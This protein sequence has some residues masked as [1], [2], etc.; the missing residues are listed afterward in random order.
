MDLTDLELTSLSSLDLV[1]LGVDK[2]ADDDSGVLKSFNYGA[3]PILLTGDI[4]PALGGDFLTTLGN[5]HGKLGLGF[6][7][8]GD[9]LLSRG[10]FEV[11]LD[12]DKFRKASEIIILNVAAIF[13]EMQGDSIRSAELSLSGRPDRIR[14]VG[15]S[16]LSDRCDMVDVHAQFDHGTKRT[17]T[18][19]RSQARTRV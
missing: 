11:Q 1:G 6:A 17:R 7:G 4:E 12:L 15:P 19:N 5:K 8:D 18:G 3:E 14:F 10:H 13:P 16:R 9:H 2:R